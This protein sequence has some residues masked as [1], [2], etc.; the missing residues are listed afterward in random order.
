ML[1]ISRAVRLAKKKSRHPC[2]KHAAIVF[3][4]KRLLAVGYNHGNVHAE[5]SAL[6]NLEGLDGEAPALSMLVIRVRRDG[7]LGLSKPCPNCRKS[8]VVEKFKHIFYT[9]SNGDIV[10]ERV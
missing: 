6:D 8:L 7:K 10:K 1:A 9:D 2:H 4:K 3:D 5:Q